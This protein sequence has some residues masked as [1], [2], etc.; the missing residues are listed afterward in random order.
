MM[1]RS[2]MRHLWL[3][4]LYGLATLVVQAGHQHGARLSGPEAVAQPGC[5]DPR[6]HY[7]S[8]GA[9]ELI[10]GELHCPACQFRAEHHAGASR[11]TSIS[12]V[13]AR[14]LAFADSPRLRPAATS[15]PTSR[16]PPL[17]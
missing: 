17:A 15:R 11:P 9:P 8:H 6:P 5:D 12:V 16:G 1:V 14:P 2:R 13:V 4:L 7:A 3:A 10:R